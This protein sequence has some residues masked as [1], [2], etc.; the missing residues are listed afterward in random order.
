MSTPFTI[1]IRADNGAVLAEIDAELE[2]EARSDAVEVTH[3]WIDG[4]HRAGRGWAGRKNYDLLLKENGMDAWR[5]GLLAKSQAEADP[6]FVRECIVQNDARQ[7]AAW[8]DE[9][10]HYRRAG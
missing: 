3:V 6:E 2:W 7:I 5:L 8:C 10:A 4:A 1:E 9:Q